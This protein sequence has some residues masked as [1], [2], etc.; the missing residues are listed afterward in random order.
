MARINIHNDEVQL[1][2][3]EPVAGS[4]FNATVT[5]NNREY[6]AGGSYACEPHMY[7]GGHLCDL[8]FEV[9]SSDGITTYNE[10]ISDI[11]VPVEGGG[12]VDKTFGVT[13]TGSG[14]YNLIFTV[15]PHGSD[16]PDQT[17]VSVDVLSESEGD[18]TEPGDGSGGDGGSGGDDGG[19]GGGSGGFDLIETA[20]ENPV[21]TGVVVVGSAY[22]ARRAIEGDE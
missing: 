9:I 16:P 3:T 1:S 13:I 22:L 7:S 17:S 20:I 15:D 4:E 12:M 11:C 5:L 21:G 10:T 2:T 19:G 18:P 6:F 8:K 14:T